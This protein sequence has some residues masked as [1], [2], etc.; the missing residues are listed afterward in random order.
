[1]L[2]KNK[3]TKIDRKEDKQKVLDLVEGKRTLLNSMKRSNG[4]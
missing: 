4:V 1:M 2:V 3:K